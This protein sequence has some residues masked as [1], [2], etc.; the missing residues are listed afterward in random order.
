MPIGRFDLPPNVQLQRLRHELSELRLKFAEKDRELDYVKET[1][2]TQLKDQLNAIRSAAKSANAEKL[3][4]MK[5]E[6][7]EAVANQKTE[8]ET[9]RMQRDALR[10]DLQAA[11]TELEMARN[12]WVQIETTIKAELLEAQK[13]IKALQSQL[14][15]A[16]SQILT[17][18]VQ[19]ATTKPAV[20]DTEGLS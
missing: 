9:V 1:A 15:T 6:R 4:V 16:R 2:A 20:R 5:R 17:E 7:D 12:S 19:D 8:I 10:I 13:S 11:Q 3:E 18:R 14:E